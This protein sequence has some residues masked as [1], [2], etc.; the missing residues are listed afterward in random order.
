MADLAELGVTSQQRFLTKGGDPADAE[1]AELTELTY[2]LPKSTEVEATFSRESLKTTL[3]KV[4]KR[5]IQ[6]GDALFDEAVNIKTDTADAAAK[7]LES[8]EIR[9]SIE[10]LVVNGGALELAG[11]TARFELPGKHVA[12]EELATNVVRALVG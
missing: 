6:T 11:A 10:S 7:L 8:T 9:A 12:T 2:T 5:E 1:T 3:L 4:F